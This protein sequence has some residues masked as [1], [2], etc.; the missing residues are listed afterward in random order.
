MRTKVKVGHVGKLADDDSSLP[1]DQLF[2]VHFENLP[3][4]AYIW[5]RTGG[6]FT[7]IAHNRAAGDL[8]FSKVGTFLGKAVRDLQRD[9]GHDL[10]GDLEACAS[11]GTVI[12]REVEHRYLETTTVRRL[13]LSLVPLSADIVVLHTDD[14]TERQRMEQ[15]LR[16]SEKKYRTI[17]DT[18]HEGIWAVDLDNVTTY[19]NQRAAEMLGYDAAQMLGRSAFDFMDP[20]V[21]EEAREIAARR[22]AGTNE[23]FDFRLRHKSGAAIWVSVAASPLTDEDGRVIGAIY[24][25]SDITARKR[26]ERALVE[27][28]AKIRALVHGTPDLIV[29]VTRD[30]RY[31][32]IHF[33]D[34]RVEDYLPRR[35]TEFVGRNVR[36]LFEPEFARRHERHRHKALATGEVQLWEY[37]RQVGEE[38]RFVEARFVKSGTD[39]VVITVRD[40]TKRVELEKEVIA[41][42]ERERTRIGHDLHDGLAQ[43]LI[44]IKLMLKALTEKLAVDD[45]KHRGD[46]ERAAD[47]VSRAIAQTSDLAQGL[48][49]IRK[50][51]SFGDALR[52]LAI[53]SERLLGVACDVVCSDVP[54]EVSESAATHLYRIAQEAITN[55]VKH[56]NATLIELRCERVEQRFALSITD[57][58]GGVGDSAT[59]KGMR[60]GMHIMQYRARSIGG[61]LIVANRPEGGTIVTCYF[62]DPS[63]IT[64]TATDT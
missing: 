62:P 9:S 10:Q 31:L 53:H 7:L 32:D 37:T 40:I 38:T 8:P 63:G 58:G 15:A 13:A 26:A 51:D 33:S 23:Q 25:M 6:D 44:G 55:A 12:K 3:G 56:G 59:D 18:A 21:H 52:Q 5:Q 27:S 36:D 49:P 2:R 11:R 19:V 16:D 50:G 24:M 46:A 57:D 60:M 20:S 61:E 43:L 45:S 48:S 4:P 14:I 28:E 22:R 34:E 17:V 42:S 35:S 54:D 47:L 39:E 41:S 30:G 1:D 64:S 29:R